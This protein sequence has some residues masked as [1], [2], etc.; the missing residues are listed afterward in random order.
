MCLA[1]AL[2]FAARN[3][4]DRFVGALTIGFLTVAAENQLRQLLKTEY[5][6][7]ELNG[8]VKLQEAAMTGRVRQESRELIRSH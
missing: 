8:F 4:G 3:F 6:E 5:D 7:D 1:S 2:A